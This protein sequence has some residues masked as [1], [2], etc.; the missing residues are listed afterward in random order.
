LNRLAQ[1]YSVC[2]GGTITTVNNVR[3]HTFTNAGTFSV[4]LNNPGVGQDLTVF[5]IGGGG[6]GGVYA[7]GGGGAG[8][9]VQGTLSVPYTAGPVAPYAVQVGAGGSGGVKSPS[10]VPGSSTVGQPGG[11]SSITDTNASN[12][13]FEAFGGGGGSTYT[14]GEGQ[15]GGC[16]GGGSYLAFRNGGD[17]GDANV[18]PPFVT[19]ADAAYNGGTGLN[20]ANA[21]GAG[22]G[23][24]GGDGGVPGS[25]AGK[26]GNGG[27]GFTF[28]GVTY[29]GGGGGAGSVN[30]LGGDGGTG[31]GGAGAPGISGQ[32]VRG[33]DA[34]PNTGSGGGGSALGDPTTTLTG[35]NGASGVVI[36]SYAYP[37]M[38]LAPNSAIIGTL[39]P[40]I[41]FNSSTSLFTL[42]AD[43]YG[44]GGT[45]S[46]NA[47]DGYS[48]N[49]DDPNNPITPS[50]KSLNSSYNDQAR[51]SWGLTGI[52]SYFSTKAY[53]IS[54]NGGQCYDERMVFEGSDYFHSLFGNWP[55]TR[56]VYLDPRLNQQ[57]S[58]VRYLPQANTA[59]LN[60]PLPLPLFVPTSV[61]S[62]Y[63]PY[64]RVAGNQAYLY[65]FPQDYPSIGNMWNPVDAI[66]VTTGV[67]PLEDDQT[68]APTIIGD[69]AY[70]K[71]DQSTSAQTER[72]L[73]EF[74]VRHPISNGQEYRNEI[75]Y[76]PQVRAMVEMRSASDLRQFDYQIK[77]RLKQ[78]QILRNLGLPDGGNANM[79]F[80]FERKG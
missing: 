10:S 79:R 24:A 39:P 72:I 63:L 28:A 76:D 62:G 65:T 17:P 68:M 25:V 16:G 70:T 80:I 47:D 78:S 73:A 14:V 33:S 26:G 12:L 64:G 71:N 42:N 13:L 69:T 67:V 51:D 34:T 5:G 48:V 15:P 45:Q 75:I 23:G 11:T 53:T 3:Y 49:V 58:Y 32:N 61:T 29:G 19:T 41:T 1:T 77:I 35:G 40:T 4:Y 52:A 2:S 59:G 31:G 54:R 8:T 50:Q 37:A 9:V 60:V 43:S 21:P 6:G 22:G 27:G 46:S 56:L 7:G 18:N 36:F 57:T 44:F 55:A 20:V 38:T 66:V 74:I 30:G